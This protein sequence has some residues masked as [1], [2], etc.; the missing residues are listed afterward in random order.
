MVNLAVTEEQVALMWGVARVGR[1]G[2]SL[3]RWIGQVRMFLG[4]TSFDV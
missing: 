4:N 1:F 3:G 2:G